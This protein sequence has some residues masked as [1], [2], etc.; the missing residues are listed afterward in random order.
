MD[1]EKEVLEPSEST[2]ILVDFWAPWCGP[3][4]VLGPVLNAVAEERSDFVLIKVNTEEEQDLA[5]A[6]QIRSIPNVKLFH[7]RA[8][9]AEFAGAL[10]A[11]QVNKWLDENL[12][13]IEKES[14]SELEQELGSRNPSDQIEMVQEFIRVHPDHVTAKHTLARLIVFQD[15]EQAFA[16]TE[17]I[18][19]GHPD[20]TLREDITALKQLVELDDPT[21]GPVQSLMLT[22]RDLLAALAF[23]EAALTITEA[24]QADRS[25]MN[26]LPRRTGIALFRIL[27][28][29]HPVTKE[30][31]RFFD[32]ALY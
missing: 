6:Y 26:D 5:N 9:I 32:M 30:R 21:D 13:S 28:N 1:F 3:C 27:G 16:L 11:V 4:R 12:P 24:V 25:Y 10:S 8:V 18:R 20:Y 2:P 31:R 19:Q 7:K 23:S 14:W 29:Q 15:P 17:D 22:V